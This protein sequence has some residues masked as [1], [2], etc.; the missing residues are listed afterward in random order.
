MDCDDF[1]DYGNN[2]TDNSTDNDTDCPE[3]ICYESDCTYYHEDLRECNMTNC[4]E[5]CW[6]YDGN[7]TVDLITWDNEYYWMDCDQFYD[8]GNNHTDN[9]TDNCTNC[10]YY[11]QSSYYPGMDWIYMND[12]YD[13]CTSEW[14]CSMEWMA[15]MYQ[16]YE[17]CEYFYTW[18]DEWNNNNTDNND[19]DYNDTDG[20]NCTTC[21]DIN[22]TYLHEDLSYCQMTDCWDNCNYDSYCENVEVWTYDG[23]SF[24]MTCDE[25]WEAFDSYNETENCTNCTTYDESMYWTD[26]DYAYMHDCYDNCTNEYF[27]DYEVSWNW[28]TYNISCDGF[29]NWYMNK[30]NSTDNDTDCPEY[31]YE[32]FDCTY[33]SDDFEWCAMYNVV[34]ECYGDDS[35]C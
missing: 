13:S 17:D 3:F 10:T 6:G 26:L 1:Y 28:Q 14:T 25:F 30:E 9:D 29:N 32:E 18:Y 20:D 19:T 15:D 23:D 12:C 24:N 31:T 4:V 7:C 34:E 35:W 27:C 21:Y 33:R 5:Q 8:Y 16:Y 11:D 2:S 22:C